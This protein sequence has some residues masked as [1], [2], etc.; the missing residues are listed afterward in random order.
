MGLSRTGLALLA[1]LGIV[2]GAHAET[3]LHRGNGAEPETLDVHKSSGVPEANIQR[4]LFEGLVAEAADGSLVPGAAESWQVSDDGTVYT[5]RLR[6]DGRWSDGTALT[7]E[8]FV[9][10]YRR[11]LDPATASD[12]AFILWP[13]KNAEAAS[14]GELADLAGIGAEALDE[15]TLRL[16]LKAPTP[17]FL[18]LLTHHMAYPVP[19][20]AIE[21]HGGRWTRPG[22]LVSNGAYRLAEWRPQSHLKLVRNE[23]YRGREQVVIDAVV[24]HPTEDGNAELKRFRAGELDVTA[25]VPSEQ[26]AWV[27]ANLPDAF[28]NTP[29]LGT[30]YYTFNLTG[31][32]FKASVELRQALALAIDRGILA[33]KVARGGEIPAY[34]WVP[35][36]V[37]DYAQQPLPFAALDQAER[38]ARAREL[39][40]AA[41]YAPDR[42]LEVEILYNTSEGHKKI[43]IAVA[44]MWRKTLGVRTTLLNQE[45]KVYLNTRSQMQFQV[46]RAGWIGDYNDANTFLELFKSDVGEMNPSGYVNPAYDALMKEAEVTS[47]PGKRADLMQRAERLL[48]ADMPI[49]PIYFYTT[50]HL[51]GPRVQGWVD[52]IMD[53]HPS[54]YLRIVD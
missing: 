32:P 10:A 40:V 53:V 6:P 16:T 42:P 20:H 1:A 9:Y 4:D 52:N 17:Y 50:Q 35:P 7:A 41:G 46:A 11:A 43:A 8:D 19:R 23:H 27:A 15:R 3:V 48:L 38:N 33:D 29:Y 54:Q 24:Y 31:A 49:I 45:W 44:A 51:V 37:R 25:N 5:F 21:A 26:I 12:Y 18:G 34:S 2:A 36:G 47:E 39:Y 13:M 30:Y 22:N 14:K 28:H